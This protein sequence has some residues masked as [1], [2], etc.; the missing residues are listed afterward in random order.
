MFEKFSESLNALQ[1]SRVLGFVRGLILVI[2][3]YKFVRL[4]QNLKCFESVDSCANYESLSFKSFGKSFCFWEI[5]VP[6]VFARFDHWPNGWKNCCLSRWSQGWTSCSSSLWTSITQINWCG[7]SSRSTWTVVIINKLVF[8]CFF[9]F[10]FGSWG[11][12]CIALRP[13]NSTY[14]SSKNTASKGFSVEVNVQI[15]N[16]TIPHWR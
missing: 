7:F 14:L 2:R 6:M 10:Y 16:S 13:R 5:L 8:V 1:L 9:M 4:L 15:W 12:S 11:W 3:I